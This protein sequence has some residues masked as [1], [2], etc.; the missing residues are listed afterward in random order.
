[1]FSPDGDTRR[2]EPPLT[3]ET[4]DLLLAKLGTRPRLSMPPDEQLADL[5][6]P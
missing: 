4:I 1:M 3:A 5:P 2:T 6:T